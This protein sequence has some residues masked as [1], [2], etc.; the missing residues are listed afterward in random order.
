MNAPQH[1][2]IDRVLEGITY[3]WN[4]LMQKHV[5]GTG[6][7]QAQSGKQNPGLFLYIP[8]NSYLS[9]DS[10]HGDHTPFF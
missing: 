9:R 1:L 4:A 5:N 8:V 7:I 3:E 2:Q 10:R 6:H